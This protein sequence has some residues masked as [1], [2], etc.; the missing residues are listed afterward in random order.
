MEEE[1]WTVKR[2]VAVN[3]VGWDLVVALDAVLAAGVHQDWSPDDVGLQEDFR[4]FDWT[5]NVAF[6][7]EVDHNVW[8]FF[9]K[10]LV[11]AFAVADVQLDEAEVWLVHNILQCWQVA[12]VSQLVQADDLIVWV[13]LH[14][15]EDKVAADEA[16]TAS[17][18]YILHNYM[19]SFIF[20]FF[21]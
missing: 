13:L 6:R 10:K 21:E 14:H 19:F 1:V 2:Q 4:I 11:D 5:V 7:S 3:F 18:Y 8:M 15:V 17:N 12:R 9:F 20:L 16:S